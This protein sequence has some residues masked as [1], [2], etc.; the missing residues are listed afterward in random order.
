M[1]TIESARQRMAQLKASVNSGAL[2]QTGLRSELSSLEQYLIS[3]RAQGDFAAEA[4]P[5]EMLLRDLHAA[6]HELTLEKAP[7]KG[8][9]PFFAASPAASAFD[10]DAIQLDADD[11]FDQVHPE[12]LVS[13]DSLSEH[14][15]SFDEP[16]ADTYASEAT[17]TAVHAAVNAESDE[18][19]ANDA[20][21]TTAMES[22][23]ASGAEKLPEVV[24]ET[25]Q[26]VTDPRV[27]FERV[28]TLKETLFG[29]VVLARDREAPGKPLVAVKLSRRDELS[30]ASHV[31]DPLHEAAV[32]RQLA[33]PG[34]HDNSDCAR[35]P[36]ALT[37]TARVATQRYCS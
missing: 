9:A 11:E 33:Q 20:V 5:A 1:T 8:V 30:R 10:D 27:R 24:S 35:V 22:A 3:L 36:R 29:H 18:A 34:M 23:H 16:E 32:M 12:Y 14:D 31:E 37:Q 26:A 2:S 21:K 28:R 25:K 7:Q 15:D 13:D 17:P 4:F 6:M 19:T